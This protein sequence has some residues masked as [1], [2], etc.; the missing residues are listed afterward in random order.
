MEQ[1]KLPTDQ[2][3]AEF[4]KLAHTHLFEAVAVLAASLKLSKIKDKDKLV[5]EIHR[6]AQTF[7]DTKNN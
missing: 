2:I 6:L 3:I 7:P 4:L 5:Q 1:S